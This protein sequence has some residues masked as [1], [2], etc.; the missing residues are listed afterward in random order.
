MKRIEQW[1]SGMT[2]WKACAP[3]ADAH[4]IAWRAEELVD[5]QQFVTL[6]DMGLPNHV[7]DKP[8]LPTLGPKVRLFSEQNRDFTRG[9]F[10]GCADFKI[11]DDGI[12]LPSPSSQHNTCRIA[13]HFGDTHEGWVELF[14]GMGSWSFAAEK[15]GQEITV[16]VGN[17]PTACRAYSKNH[18]SKI[19]Q[20]SVNDLNWLPTGFPKAFLISLPCP[21]FSC[22]KGIPG[23]MSRSA[24]SWQEMAFALR[25]C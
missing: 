13:N 22:L 4:L 5:G 7:N 12:Y 25:L 17:C 6:V 14:A 19:R 15:M 16:A 1:L 23:L 10:Y 8:V 18:T 3:L 11:T 9:A 24:D 21:A 20:M 2:S